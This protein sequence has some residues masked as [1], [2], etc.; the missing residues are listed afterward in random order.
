MVSFTVEYRESIMTTAGDE[1]FFKESRLTQGV[2]EGFF[3]IGPRSA[4]KLGHAGISEI[5]SRVEPECGTT[6][7]G[8]RR[9]SWARK[10]C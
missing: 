3:S 1:E 8:R 5:S 6:L 2:G 4:K 7:K 10:K 9:S